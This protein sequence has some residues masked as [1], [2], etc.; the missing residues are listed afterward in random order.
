MSMSTSQ[1]RKAPSVISDNYWGA[2]QL[3]ATLVSR[4]KTQTSSERD[5]FYF[6]GGARV[7]TRPSVGFKDSP[8]PGAAS[9]AVDSEQIRTCGYEASA[10]QAEIWPSLLPDRRPSARPVPPS[11]VSLEG[12]V[13]FLKTLPLDEVCRC[14]ICSYDGTPSPPI[15][16][17][18][19]T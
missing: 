19:F 11:S 7:I 1:A 16:G 12:A 6:L 17:F 10:A 15:S 18:R 4:S 9:F 5:R 8:T 14:T 3:T 13:R 2:T